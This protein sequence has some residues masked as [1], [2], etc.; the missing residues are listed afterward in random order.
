VLQQRADRHDEKSPR[1]IRAT[2]AG[3]APRSPTNPVFLKLFSGQSNIRGNIPFELDEQCKLLFKAE[4]GA[5]LSIF[6]HERCYF[7]YVVLSVP[8][9]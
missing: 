8:V 1:Q 9:A 3:R 2:P 5:V 6:W 4:Q 7:L